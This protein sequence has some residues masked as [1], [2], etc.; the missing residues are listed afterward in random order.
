[1]LNWLSEFFKGMIPRIKRVKINP[2]EN[3][4][5]SNSLIPNETVKQLG[6]IKRVETPISIF[7][8]PFHEPS[9][10]SFFGRFVQN[11]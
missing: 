6:E 11:Q 1:M 5:D 4:E 7:P 3:G 2:D 10:L 8:L 9:V